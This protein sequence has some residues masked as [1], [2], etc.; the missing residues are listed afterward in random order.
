ML[1][2]LVGV[3]LAGADVVDVARVLAVES[4]DAQRRQVAADRRVHHAEREVA[5]AAA[6]DMVDAAE[7]ARFDPAEGRGG[8]QVA[9]RAAGR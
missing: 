9:N 2:Q 4:D 7:R 8:E 6:R 5:C 1:V 3:L